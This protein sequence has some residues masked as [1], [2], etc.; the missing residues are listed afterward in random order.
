MKQLKKGLTG[1]IAFDTITL[2]PLNHCSGRQAPLLREGGYKKEDSIGRGPLLFHELV[3]RF[4]I[5]F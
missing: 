3:V 2:C 5:V 4:E 1:R